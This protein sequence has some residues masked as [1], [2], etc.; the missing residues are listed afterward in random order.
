MSDTK[1]L[2]QFPAAVPGGELIPYL[3]PKQR[4]ALMDF[5]YRET[6]GAQGM[7]DWIKRDDAHRGQFYKMW[8]KGAARP[9]S[10]T[11]AEKKDGRIEQL[12]ARLDA[13]ESATVINGTARVVEADT[14]ESGDDE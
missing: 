9:S 1:D 2:A 7:V 5:V 4:G 14:P 3:S 13:G 10:D 8:S 11:E 6:G 12:L